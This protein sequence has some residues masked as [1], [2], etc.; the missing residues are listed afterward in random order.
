MRLSMIAVCL[1]LLAPCSVS[2]CDDFGSQPAGWIHEMRSSF[3]KFEWSRAEEMK[4]GGMSWLWL[5]GAGSAAVALVAVSFRGLARAGG[6]A[7]ILEQ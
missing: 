3:R 2:A 1:L 5:S 4:E 6:G 7:P